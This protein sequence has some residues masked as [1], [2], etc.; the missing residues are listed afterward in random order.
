MKTRKQMLLDRAMFMMK[1]QV[2]V[3]SELQFIG[4]KCHLRRLEDF[5]DMKWR[6]TTAGS[7]I[8]IQTAL[9]IDKRESENKEESA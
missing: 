5:A 8:L 2:K 4:A 3:W 1:Y 6:E 7:L 9:N